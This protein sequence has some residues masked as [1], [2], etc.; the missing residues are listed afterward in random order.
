M[1][2]REV[3]W[4][5]VIASC[6]KTQTPASCQKTQTTAAGSHRS[7]IPVAPNSATI[8]MPK[9][10]LSTITDPLGV[11]A[12]QAD[13]GRDGRLGGLVDA[14]G[15]PSKLEYDITP[16]GSTVSS[17][18]TGLS[19]TSSSFDGY[20]RLVTETTAS[21]QT[22]LYT[23]LT[24]TIRYPHQTI[25]VV[26]DPDGPEA[27]RTLSGDDRVTTRG[28]HPEFDGAVTT[29]TDPD[30]N[31]SI[32]AYNT[33]SFSKGTGLSS[34]RNHHRIR[35][36]RLQWGWPTEKSKGSG[37]FVWFLLGKPHSWTSPGTHRGFQVKS[38]G[39]RFNP[40]FISKRLSTLC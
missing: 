2:V 6:Q 27:W 31:T 17:E 32:T 30:G 38:S 25:Q 4:T 18:S 16:E 40:A 22:T 14:Q 11:D 12:L 1:D 3:L 26:G 29:E 37:L 34:R 13:Y 21:G 9:A 19:Q 23:Y 8:T 24:D 39:D 20:G 10:Y 28:Y 5:R 33:W 15:N 36:A 7:P 35:L